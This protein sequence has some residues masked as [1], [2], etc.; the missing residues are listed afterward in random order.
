M[1]HLLGAQQRYCLR[2]T[3][4]KIHG[5]STGTL[6]P[7]LQ[8]SIV[9]CL[10]DLL[11]VAVPL[12]PVVTLSIIFCLR[13]RY[14][15]YQ[16]FLIT[17]LIWLTDLFGKALFR[18]QLATLRHRLDAVNSSNPISSMHTTGILDALKTDLK[19]EKKS[20]ENK[21][22]CALLQVLKSIELQY[23]IWMMFLLGRSLAF[24]SRFI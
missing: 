2:I 23:F 12:I 16:T 11:V 13:V 7:F 22:R 18:D 20:S 17:I 15:S 24:R 19:S 5:N 21:L 6:I 1:S 14:I 3:H 4:Y 9:L 8:K 10:I